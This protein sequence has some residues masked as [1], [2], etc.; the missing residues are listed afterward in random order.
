M[1]RAGP[2]WPERD[3]VMDRVSVIEGTLGKAV[4]VMG[5]YITGS[6]GLVDVVRSFAASF[7]FTTS[8]T[9]SSAA[10]AL[11]SVRHLKHAP[12]LRA[13]HQERAATLKRLLAK[14]G[15]PV[16]QSASHIVPVLVGDAVLCKRV[17]DDL[18]DR[19]GLYIQP[20]NYPTVP[21][22]TE[23]LRITPTPFHSDADMADL[24]EALLEVW[25]QLE[26]RK[27]A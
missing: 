14:A 7:I 23:R 19:H 3:G 4:G 1:V 2:A 6:A 13:R 16:M 12:D 26:L 17:S 8:L 11:A 25:G 5:G 27:V 10:G 15:L 24:V 22:G 21:R 9:P 18:L 20:I